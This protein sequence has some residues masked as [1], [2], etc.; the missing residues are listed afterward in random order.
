MGHKTQ[1]QY[2]KH[3]KRKNRESKPIFLKKTGIIKIDKI[4]QP[5]K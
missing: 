3:L 2:L 5:L 1:Y 4:L